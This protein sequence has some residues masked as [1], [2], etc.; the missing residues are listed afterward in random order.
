[1]PNSPVNT[2]PKGGSVEVSTGVRL[3]F[4]RVFQQAFVPPAGAGAASNAAVMAG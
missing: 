2:K 3:G 1:M 4:D